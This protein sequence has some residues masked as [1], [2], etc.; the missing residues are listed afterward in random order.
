MELTTRRHV[1]NRAIPVFFLLD[2]KGEKLIWIYEGQKKVLALFIQKKH[3]HCV[4]PYFG[5]KNIEIKCRFMH[6]Y[7][8]YFSLHFLL[9]ARDSFKIFHLVL[10]SNKDEGGGD[11]K[12]YIVKKKKLYFNCGFNPLALGG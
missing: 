4:T 12:K 1:T 8:L 7:F 5:V 3:Q 11:L 6:C 2:C 10:E 9:Q